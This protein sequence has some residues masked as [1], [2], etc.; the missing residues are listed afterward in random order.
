MRLAE[1]PTFRVINAEDT[2]GAATVAATVAAQAVATAVALAAATAAALAAATAAVLVEDMAADLAAVI[3]GAPAADLAGEAVL[4]VT[5]PEDLDIILAPAVLT[6]APAVITL[7]PADITPAPAAMAALLE[8]FSTQGREKRRRQ[9]RRQ[10][11]KDPSSFSDVF[12]MQRVIPGRQRELYS[13]WQH[14]ADIYMK[15]FIFRC[16]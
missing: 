1:L 3:L 4:A 8:E 7:A 11:A 2:E 14:K 15:I 6:P 16:L 9:R 10:I 5:G 13:C 12:I